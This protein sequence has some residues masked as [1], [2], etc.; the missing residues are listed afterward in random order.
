MQLKDAI[1]E[2]DACKTCFPEAQRMDVP[3]RDLHALGAL[4]NADGCDACL[5][6]VIALIRQHQE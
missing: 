2:L 4:L 1:R 6:L 3:V 5:E